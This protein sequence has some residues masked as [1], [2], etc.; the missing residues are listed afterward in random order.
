MDAVLS[1]GRPGIN[2]TIHAFNVIAQAGASVV[3]RDGALHKIRGSSSRAPVPAVAPDL[4][5][6]IEVVQSN[7]TPGQFMVVGRK[8]FRKKVEP[9]IAIAFFQVTQHLIVSAVFFNDINDVAD[10]A[11]PESKKLLAVGALRRYGEMVISC[12]QQG[13]FFQFRELTRRDYQQR[14]YFQLPHILLVKGARAVIR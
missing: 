11:S 14:A 7:E 9:G 1:P 5:A 6:I 13:K 12:R 10:L 4:S 2:A 3:H 8:R